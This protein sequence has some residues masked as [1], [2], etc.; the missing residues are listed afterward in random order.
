MNDLTILFAVAIAVFA[1]LAFAFIRK[2][3]KRKAM[4]R[5]TCGET[6]QPGGTTNPANWFIGPVLSEHQGGNKSPGMPAHPS[7]VEG[8]FTFAIPQGIDLPLKTGPKVDYLTFRHGP[9]TGKTLI[10]MRYRL[11]REAGVEVYAV[12]EQ[13]PTSRA[14]AQL[15][16]H[17]QREGD[18]W[19][20]RGKFEAYRWYRPAGYLQDGEHEIVVPLDSGWTATQHSTSAS[21]PS[22][23]KD[24]IDHACC[25]GIV[26]GGN[27]VGYG[28]GMRATGPARF[29]VLEF[30]VE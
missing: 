30:T 6:A 21:N 12:P 16:M 11:E 5:S 10:R 13:V 26:F 1:L 29:S 20:A 27:E 14:P 19:T 24:A 22:G 4:T 9:L 15:T 28:H 18:D 8:G 2:S 3:I 23:F 7:A 17:F 25:V